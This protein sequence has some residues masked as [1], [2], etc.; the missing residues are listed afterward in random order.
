MN[1]AER[2]S[3]LRLV[4]QAENVGAC[5]FPSTDPH[6]SEYPAACWKS[7]EWISGFIGSA[8]TVVVTADKAGL[9]TD[10][11]YFIQAETQLRDTGIQLYKEKIPGTPTVN[12]W[13]SGELKKG[14][15][16]GLDGAVF[17]ASD[18][19]EL[20]TY[21]HK[22]G[23][24]LNTKFTPLN[25]LWKDCPE[26]PSNNV[27]LLPEMFSGASSSQKIALTLEAIHREGAN[28]SILVSLDMIAW[29]FNIRSN[30]VDYNPVAVSYAYVSD[31][32]T[33][34]FI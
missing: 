27:F 6:L 22:H 21:L 3:A 31:K 33:V 12:E 26:I 30:D 5:I 14:E 10:S 25:I 34:L 17:A 13:L 29:L 32:E 15:I 9:W 19:R 4:M 20:R 11:R 28:A 8:G 2:L 24:V 18:T 16:V 23:L 1:I 7:R